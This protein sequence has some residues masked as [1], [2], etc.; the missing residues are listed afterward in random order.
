M[1][2]RD[3]LRDLHDQGRTIVLIT[4]EHEVAAQAGRVVVM[5]DGRLQESSVAALDPRGVPR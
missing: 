4:H 5:R 2:I 3:R 1:C